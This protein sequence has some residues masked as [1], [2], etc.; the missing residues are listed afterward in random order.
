[1]LVDLFEQQDLCSAAFKRGKHRQ[2]VHVGRRTSLSVPFIVIP[3][4]EGQYPI[5]VKAAVKDSMLSDG[6][7]KMLHVVVRERCHSH[8][9][10]F[11]KPWMMA[12]LSF[13]F[14]PMAS[15]LKFQ[16]QSLLIQKKWE[17]VRLKY[18]A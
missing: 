18:T 5:E 13:L 15:W 12:Q 9:Q 14:S 17:K 2:A 10:G 16:R 11:T 8:L 6:I 4:K 7:K 1:M 3:K